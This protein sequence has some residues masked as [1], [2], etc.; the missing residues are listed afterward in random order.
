LIEFPSKP[1]DRSF[2]LTDTAF[3]SIIND[4]ATLKSL[5]KIDFRF[6]VCHLLTDKSLQNISKAINQLESLQDV[7]LS[8]DK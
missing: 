1:A 6:G 2:A 3:E 7:A 8:F 4:W 5:E